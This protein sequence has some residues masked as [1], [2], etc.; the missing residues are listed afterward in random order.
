MVEAAMERLAAPSSRVVARALWRVFSSLAWTDDQFAVV[1]ALWRGFPDRTRTKALQILALLLTSQRPAVLRLA[2]SLERT[3][4][5]LVLPWLFEMQRS[6]RDPSRRQAMQSIFGVCEAKLRRAVAQPTLPAAPAGQSRYYD[7]AVRLM[8]TDEQVRRRFLLRHDTTWRGLHAAIQR[9]S[10]AWDDALMWAFYRKAGKVLVADAA[11]SD[12]CLAS[13]SERIATLVE[14]GHRS[15]VYVYDFGDNWRLS[16]AIARNAV[17]QP[18]TG[19]QRLLSGQ[20]A[21]PPE[22]CG[23]MWGFQQLVGAARAR[24][25]LVS[26]GA[27]AA[28]GDAGLEDDP[29]DL[30]DWLD[31]WRHFDPDVFDFDACKADFDD[32]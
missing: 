26:R 19:A 20:G 29:E 32:A 24:K 31:A 25:A 28:P 18:G 21:F 13:G 7:V 23:G 12:D 30:D 16:V 27:A 5:H 4:T 8:G 17:L 14:A 15:F 22:D 1:E 6:V 10:A 2:K 3:E 9:A 11:D